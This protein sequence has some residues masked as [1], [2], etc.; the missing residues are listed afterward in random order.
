VTRVLIV[1]SR[2]LAVQM[3]RQLAR[4]P[5][6]QVVG[7]LDDFRPSGEMTDWGPVLGGTADA[8][9]LVGDGRADA[10]AVGIGYK[11]LAVRGR[12][13]ETL[14]GRVPLLAWA[15][16]R[17]VVDPAARLR[18]GAWVS[19]GSVV[20][21]E[22]EIGEGAFLNLSCT[23]AHDSSV[24]GNTFLAPGVQVAGFAHV[25]RGCF[26]GTGTIVID[27]VRVADGVTTGAGAVVTK[28]ITEPGL[29]VGVPARKLR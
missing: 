7:F 15:H 16:A 13:I 21:A 12:L 8:E 9:R 27:N 10:V 1:G 28:T 19:A 25:G 17:A 29:Y 3:A 20:D 11:H 26:L 23:V 6:T 18:P 14:N 24:G 2:D 22:V 4:D 5:A